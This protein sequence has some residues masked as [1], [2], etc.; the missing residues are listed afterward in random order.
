MVPFIL[1]I[2]IISYSAI[3]KI[4]FSTFFI[5]LDEEYLNVVLETKSWPDK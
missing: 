4:L 5:K 1:F 3:N 2:R